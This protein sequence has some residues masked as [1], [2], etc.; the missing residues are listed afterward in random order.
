MTFS[1]F[2]LNHHLAAEKRTIYSESISFMNYFPQ[3]FMIINFYNGFVLFRGHPKSF[4]NL[5]SAVIFNLCVSFLIRI[6]EGNF[7]IMRYI[8]R[9]GRSGRSVSLN[10]VCGV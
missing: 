8:F 10:E 1:P 2:P 3:H 9:S 4:Y 6:I 7:E 5:V